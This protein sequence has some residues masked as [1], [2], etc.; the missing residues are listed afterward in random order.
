[1]DRGEKLKR[2]K[3]RVARANIN[4]EDSLWLLIQ[5]EI[6]I[7]RAAIL[8]KELS[9]YASMTDKTTVTSGFDIGLEARQA[10][11][12]YEESILGEYED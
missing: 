11:K 9:W 7:E 1:M 12:N 6:A 8:V 5:L 3:R 2:I 10:V 4:V